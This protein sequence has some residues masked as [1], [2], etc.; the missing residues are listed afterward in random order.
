MMRLGAVPR[1]EV[2]DC[3]SEPVWICG[4]E[5][6]MGS[7]RILGSRFFPPKRAPMPPALVPDLTLSASAAG[8]GEAERRAGVKA[9]FSLPTG[10]TPR[11]LGVMSMVLAV[12]TEP[13]SAAVN[14]WTRAASVVVV[15]ESTESMVSEVMRGEESV[16][17]PACE[18]CGDMPGRRTGGLIGRL[19][20]TEGVC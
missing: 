4:G 6:T 17:R 20:G 12:L 9:S 2:V 16:S 10:E 13:S 11:L 18:L 19:V 14:G 3:V 15:A 1:R 8:F 5:A 7:S